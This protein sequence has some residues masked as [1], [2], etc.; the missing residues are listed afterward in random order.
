MPSKKPERRLQCFACLHGSN[1]AFHWFE[2]GHQEGIWATFCS[3][4]ITP[5]FSALHAPAETWLSHLRH[6][7]QWKRKLLCWFHWS[8]AE[9]VCRAGGIEL[10]SS[11]AFLGGHACSQGWMWQVLE[12]PP[13]SAPRE[14][15][16]QCKP[17]LA[18]RPCQAKRGGRWAMSDMGNLRLL[19]WG[20]P[21]WGPCELVSKTFLML[22]GPLYLLFFL[23]KISF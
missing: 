4:S 23:R 7:H 9:F 1:L 14:G 17:L 20:T 6:S 5:L 12:D 22:G 3:L 11:S 16:R 13:G 8:V 18:E 10:G 15:G 19:R 21:A 2:R